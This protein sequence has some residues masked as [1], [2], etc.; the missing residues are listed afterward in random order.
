MK[1]PINEN[2]QIYTEKPEHVLICL[3]VALNILLRGVILSSVFCNDF[4]LAR[5]AVLPQ[6]ALLGP[7][8]SFAVL[9]IFL[10]F[11]LMTVDSAPH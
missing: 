4:F 5:R 9:I 11:L 1:W 8:L 10:F 3:V 6:S 2:A 7:T